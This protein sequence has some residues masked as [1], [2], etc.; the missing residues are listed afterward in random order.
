MSLSIVA[1]LQASATAGKTV[2]LT[3]NGSTSVAGTLVCSATLEGPYIL[4]TSGGTN[5]AGGDPGTGVLAFVRISAE[6]TPT[7]T[8]ADYPLL[9]GQTAILQNPVP[10]G[11]AGIAVLST[12]T[13]NV[14]IFFTP[15]AGLTR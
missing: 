11:T 1:P 4:V 6:A 14:D 8:A 10:N 9:P 3:T 5:A 2:K 13:T 15:I 7:A 12:G